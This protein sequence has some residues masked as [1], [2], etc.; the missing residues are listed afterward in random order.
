MYITHVEVGRASRRTGFTL[1]E[2]L[3]VIGIIAVLIGI[4]L[5]SLAKARRSAQQVA[6]G[7]N[8]RQFFNAIMMYHQD[9]KT[10]PGPM[11]RATLSP[12]KAYNMWL[13]HGNAAL[14]SYWIPHS[15]A[16]YDGL[17]SY[18]AGHH[19]KPGDAVSKV[20]ECPANADLFEV[21]GCTPAAAYAGYNLG[22]SYI[23]NNQSDTNVPYFFGYTYNG[24]YTGAATDLI[25]KR[26]AQ[27]RAAGLNLEKRGYYMRSFAEIWMM[28]DVDSFNF[29]Y[30]VSPTFGIDKTLANV[31]GGLY[32]MKYQPVHG[33]GSAAGGRNYLFFDGHVQYVPFGKLNTTDNSSFPYNAWNLPAD[34]S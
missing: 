13:A 27:V 14:N 33:R 22:F 24:A 26:L 1:V 23:F 6:C 28:S 20:F 30:T 15:T 31:P 5:P 2:L 29:N 16:S 12:D 18:L 32:N 17:V 21:G 10:L 9:W 3:V 19:Q 8:L 11:V 34:V 4:L 7:S 25:P